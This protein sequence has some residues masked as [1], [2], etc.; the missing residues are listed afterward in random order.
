MKTVIFILMLTLSATIANAQQ[1]RKQTD[2]L[3]LNQKEIPQDTLEPFDRSDEKHIEFPNPNRPP[4]NSTPEPPR[5]EK[6]I[7]KK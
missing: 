6:A 3:Q 4:T 5:K 1:N 2:T 7:R